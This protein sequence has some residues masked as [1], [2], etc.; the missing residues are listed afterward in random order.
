MRVAVA[1]G[2]GDGRWAGERLGDWSAAAESTIGRCGCYVCCL[3]MVA[4][5]FGHGV[6]PVEM[7]GELRER[8]MTAFGAQSG[9]CRNNAW[10]A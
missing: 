9:S 10:G 4:T 3:A 5:A 6:T 1:Y 8:G 2:Q 7:S